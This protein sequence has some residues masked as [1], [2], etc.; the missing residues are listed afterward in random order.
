MHPYKDRL[1]RIRRILRQN[2]TN[3]YYRLC[4]NL[5]GSPDSCKIIFRVLSYKAPV[6]LLQGMQGH[7]TRYPDWKEG[8]V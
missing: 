7:T 6:D 2:N 1:L 5:L 4:P 8:G 3:N